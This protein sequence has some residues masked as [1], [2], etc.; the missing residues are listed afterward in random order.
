[1]KFLEGY[2]QNLLQS[3][4]KALVWDCSFAK[5]LYKPMVEEYGLKTIIISME[6]G[7]RV[8]GGLLLH[9]VCLLL[10]PRWMEIINNG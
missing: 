7:I 2:F 6:M 4:I 5:V 3:H 1:V 10:P 9:L 8:V